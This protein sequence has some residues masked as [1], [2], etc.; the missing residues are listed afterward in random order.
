MSSSAEIIK[1]KKHSCTNCGQ[2]FIKRRLSQESTQLGFSN[3]YQL[4]RPGRNNENSFSEILQKHNFEKTDFQST[5]DNSVNSVN[6]VRVTKPKK[7][8]RLSDLVPPSFYILDTNNEDGSKETPSTFQ[9]YL[10]RKRGSDG[11][12]ME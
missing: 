11:I 9:S 2:T 1:P 7:I 12:F 4:K 6:S 3:D 10:V 8:Y 5:K